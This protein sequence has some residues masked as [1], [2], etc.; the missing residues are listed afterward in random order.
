MKKM[1]EYEN[2]IGM[3]IALTIS[4]SVN[5]TTSGLEKV[6]KSGGIKLVR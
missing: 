5:S 1:L 6:V 4:K 2:R 3:A